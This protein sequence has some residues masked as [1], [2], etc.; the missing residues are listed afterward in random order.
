MHLEK[1]EVFRV[2][3]ERL[4]PLVAN[5]DSL[6]REVGLTEIDYLFK[7]VPQGGTKVTASARGSSI[8][9]EWEEH[10]FEWVW[11]RNY[12]IRRL[13]TRGP[14]HEFRATFRLE[15]DPAGSRI[16]V[17]FDLEP[18]GLIGRILAATAGKS[19]AVQML[20]AAK[21]FERY[22]LG[23]LPSPYPKRYGRAAV[24]VA[25]VEAGIRRL[26]ELPVDP[27]LA[28][29]LGHHLVEEVDERV[30]DIRPFA[31]AD[32]WKADRLAVL[33]LCL[34]ATR[35]GLLDLRWHLICPACMGSKAE[36]ES[37][38]DL[39]HDENCVS[40]NL[41]FRL[42]LDKR[43]EVRFTPN[44]SVRAPGSGQYCFGG[45]M[46][47]P[48]IYA[49]LVLAPG[50]SRTIEQSFPPG[51]YGVRRAGM[52]ETVAIDV[53]S[54]PP[55][56]EIS[57]SDGGIL[58]APVASPGTLTLKNETKTPLRVT[59][60]RTG[61]GA[62]A[63]AAMVTAMQEFR[64]LFSSEALAPGIELSIGTLSFLFSDLKDSTAM[65]AKIGDS[66]AY[67]VVRKHFDYMKERIRRHEGA[68]VK[69][70]GDAV[71]AVFRRPADAM[72]C[73]LAMQKERP[74]EDVG[75]KLG[76]HIGPCIAVSASDYLD[77]FGSTVNIAARAQGQSVGDDIVATGAIMEQ[78]GVAEV[79]RESGAHE[80]RFTAT[81][82]G[83]ED[84]FTLHRLVFGTPGET[85][86]RK[87]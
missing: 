50:E 53:G 15:P 54:G 10:P 81:L 34:W 6:N 22:L 21:N 69:T 5:T 30:R 11:Q 46:N 41:K 20:E 39:K 75:I 38:K 56:A 47:T 42:D 35:A 84:Q 80:S 24:D 4:W 33:R 37:L 63:S 78:P 72:R 61:G 29:R 85:V 51:R 17:S 8:A 67:A 13:F 64:D 49:Q 57:F 77:Y 60:E 14:F 18:A 25:A 16:H 7:P 87:T 40:C 19:G 43:V 58:A 59:L 9:M 71:M 52:H 23:E 76:L 36:H 31:L 3:P 66:P 70:M 55:K 68:L 2:P 1:T 44:R 48:H 65:Y 86:V 27:A 45:P 79:I 73:A 28:D 62:A 12:V 32:E 83:Y 74:K 26:K 82:K